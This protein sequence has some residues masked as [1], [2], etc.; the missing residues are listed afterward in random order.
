MGKT[1]RK[2]T[3][4]LMA[5]VLALFGQMEGMSYQIIQAQAAEKASSL[6]VSS[7]TFEYMDDPY[8]GESYNNPIVSMQWNT[9]WSGSYGTILRGNYDFYWRDVETGKILAN[10]DIFEKGKEYSL[11]LE[12]PCEFD[13]CTD[14]DT[15]TYYHYIY[16][17]DF[18]GEVGGV[19][20]TANDYMI[21]DDKIIVKDIYSKI[22]IDRPEDKI[23][24]HSI[25]F[26][27]ISTKLY[28]GQ[29]T[30]TLN[31]WTGYEETPI[32]INGNQKVEK[33][34][35]LDK[36]LTWGLYWVKLDY[37]AAADCFT[38]ASPSDS[39]SYWWELDL[40][41]IEPDTYYGLV[42]ILRW[43]QYKNGPEI[44]LDA[45]SL[46][47]GNSSFEFVPMVNGTGM[48]SNC[49]SVF[50]GGDDGGG[51]D[52]ENDPG[53]SYISYRLMAGVFAI[54]KSLPDT[55]VKPG[56]TTVPQTQKQDKVTVPKVSKVKAVKAEEKKKKLILKWKKSS[57]VSGYQL[58]ISTKKN[59]KGARK[60]SISKSK[61]TYTKKGLK[62]KKKYN[63][64]I[65]AYKTYK[66][67]DKKTKKVYGKWVTV[68]KKTK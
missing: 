54:T 49:E 41:K 60:I 18:H 2:T 32:Y 16:E 51:I 58:Q 44:A 61:N 6:N 37:N 66:D 9:G 23:R 42:M 33:G 67:V 5:A 48:V 57:G 25:D 13:Q 56:T 62:K 65:R 31:A 21:E 7:V 64:R 45:E 27:N 22:C 1:W 28:E 17:K 43:N 8:T 59:F 40:K 24:I 19:T 29:D 39:S 55:N 4:L 11:T 34:S 53:T 68:N 38:L 30:N 50:A 52:D 12:L 63:I 35:V 20:F 3:A 15:G 26:R 10:T 47:Y 46:D 36:N 14:Y